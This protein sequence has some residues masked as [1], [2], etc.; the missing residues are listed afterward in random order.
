MLTI[1]PIRVPK[2]ESRA[3][4]PLWVKSGH[5]RTSASLA[6]AGLAQ[7][8]PKSDNADKANCVAPKR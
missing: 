7:A 5:S 1:W 3:G 2:V 8:Q 6:Q 4:C